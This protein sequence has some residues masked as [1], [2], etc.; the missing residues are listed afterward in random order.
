MRKTLQTSPMDTKIR[1]ANR[2]VNANKRA[3][4]ELQQ[5]CNAVKEHGFACSNNHR[6]V[7]YKR[8][9]E[10]KSLGTKRSN[11]RAALIPSNPAR[12]AFVY[13]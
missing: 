4:I 7:N 6:M 3:A 10:S 5:E 8:V 12:K 9:R 11:V 1:K 2:V 13:L